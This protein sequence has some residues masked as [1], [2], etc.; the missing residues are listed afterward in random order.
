MCGFAAALSLDGLPIDTSRLKKMA[1]G[2]AHRGPDGEGFYKRPWVGLAHKRLSI[3]GIEGGAQPFCSGALSMVYNGEVYNHA[4]L[5][6][7]LELLGIVFHS[8][9]DTEVVLKAYEQWGVDAFS[10]FDGMFSIAIFDENTKA[11]VVA[12]DR[13]GIKPLYVC[14]DLNGTRLFASEIQGVKG[15]DTDFDWPLDYRGLDNFMRIGYYVEPR[16]AYKNI[17]QITPGTVEIHKHLLQGYEKFVF[18][19]PS[20]SLSKDGKEIVDSEGLSLIDESVKSQSMRDESVVMGTFLSGGLDSTLLTSL[21]KQHDV[22]FETFSAGFD[23]PIFNEIPQAKSTA[24]KL[25]LVNNSVLLTSA[26]LEQAQKIPSL[27]GA[28]F[29]DNAA[30]PTYSVAESA[31]KKGVKV[32]LSGDGA[33]ELFLGY[34]NHYAIY[35]ENK[36]KQFIPEGSIFQSFMRKLGKYYPNS[37]SVPRLLRAAST[38]SSL[39]MPLSESYCEAMSV[40]SRGIVNSLYSSKMKSELD[41]FD[42]SF[43]FKQLQSE[44]EHDDPMKQLQYLDF[45]TYLPGSVLTKLDRATMRAGIESRVPF[46]SN[47]LVDRVLSQPSKLNISTGENKKQLRSWARNTVYEDSRKRV[48]KSFTSP[49]DHWFRYLQEDRF[50][51]IILLD[52]LV[53][54][55]LFDK[56]SLLKI[57][58]EHQTGVRNHGTLLWSLAVLSHSL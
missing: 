35:M 55:G 2:I 51:C 43:D 41:G 11:L 3:V 8:K 9:S 39:G 25:G 23:I 54:S 28:A 21:L 46:L 53:D 31:A 48:K 32:M 20:D 4:S 50:C 5:R 45:K 12:R 15:F 56:V 24:D 29:G 14:D 33:D 13:F 58:N 36:I 16:T 38:F 47:K 27:Y 17:R 37:P 52:N 1:L 30:Y 18:W 10:R 22:D 19:K 44:F 57:K 26:M 34:K 40:S 7:E 6:E 42:T 49:L